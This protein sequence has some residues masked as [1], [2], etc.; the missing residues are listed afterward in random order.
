MADGVQPTGFANEVG[1]V[2]AERGVEEPVEGGAGGDRS[3][4]DLTQHFQRALHIAG[5]TGYCGSQW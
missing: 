3:G 5:F 4:Q 1:A 2:E